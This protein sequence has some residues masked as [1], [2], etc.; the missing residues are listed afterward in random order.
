VKFFFSFFFERKS[1]AAAMIVF[2]SYAPKISPLDHR[3][4]LCKVIFG[5][6]IAEKTC[7]ANT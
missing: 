3:N 7:G 4:I 1:E 6:E 5:F 2:G